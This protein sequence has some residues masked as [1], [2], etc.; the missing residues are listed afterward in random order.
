M[1]E[2]RWVERNERQR[3]KEDVHRYYC[4]SKSRWTV[5][6][7]RMCIDSNQAWIWEFD[8]QS[9]QHHWIHQHHQAINQERLYNLISTKMTETKDKIIYNNLSIE[10]EKLFAMSNCERNLAKVLMITLLCKYLK[11]SVKEAHQKALQLRPERESFY[12]LI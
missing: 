2:N 1:I 7:E 12:S 3:L 4:K 5:L 8:E 10:K 11:V 6:R 9:K